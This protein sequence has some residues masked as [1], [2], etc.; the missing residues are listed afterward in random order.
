M[1][2]CLLVTL[3]VAAAFASSSAYANKL[4]RF[5]VDG[6]TVLKDHIPPELMKY[7]Y[8][9]LGT[10]GLV[11]EVIPPPPTPEELARIRAAKKAEERRKQ[12]QATQ[13]EIDQDLMRLY[14]RPEDVE[15]ARLRKADE[16][17]TYIRLQ[18][19]RAEG[20]ESK[21]SAVQTRAASFERG[22]GEVPA[23]LRAEV[24]E[25]QSALSETERDISDRRRELSRI[26]REY[27]EQF[28]RIRILQVYPQGTLYEDVDF[29]R[30]ERE[31]A[32]TAGSE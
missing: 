2:A 5:N 17:Q 19:K 3:I 28:E 9:V 12:A 25:L 6:R 15:R 1:K 7:G 24:S 31:L 8:E 18:Q 11:I 16:V 13:K 32:A 30:L 27:A 4:Y 21:L 10:N 29:E 23:D 26:T 22:G 20:L 14:E